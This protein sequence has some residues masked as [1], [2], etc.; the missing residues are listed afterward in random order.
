MSVTRLSAALSQGVIEPLEGTV[1]WVNPDPAG[2]LEVEGTLVLVS[3]DRVIHD[4]ADAVQREIPECDTVIVTVPRA[5]AEAQ[6]AIARACRMA[7][8]R[9]IIDGQKTDGID[10]IYKSVKTRLGPVG[11]Y[12]K[13]HG[14]VFSIPPSTAFEDWAV[15]APRPGPEGF[16][17]LPGVFS[18]DRIDP[19]SALLA[20]ALPEGVKGVVADLG[21]GWGYLSRALLTQERVTTVHAVESDARALDCARE[22]LNDPRVQFHWADV[23]QWQAPEPLDA[24]VMNPPFH[25]GRKGAPELGQGFIRTAARGLKP[26]GDLWM[27]AN[28][29]LPYE[30]T[31]A[32]YFTQVTELSGD[33]A[34][35]LFHATRPRRNG[36]TG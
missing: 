16:V 28:R 17:T 32:Q 21:A 27:V 1:A 35:K 2:G 24:V 34:F 10:T 11:S 8:S 26:R 25:Q 23:T 12:S 14:R 30:A 20:Q 29:H 3:D 6:D 5:R 22:N 19:G 7:R 31:L 33:G 13:A 36:A 4:R 15:D 18:A 9:V